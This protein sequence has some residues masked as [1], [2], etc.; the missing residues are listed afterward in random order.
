MSG[1]PGE[2]TGGMDARPIAEVPIH[3]TAPTRPTQPTQLP[4]ANTANPQSRTADSSYSPPILSSPART[5]PTT[6]TEPATQ[7][8][9]PTEPAAQEYRQPAAA[10]PDGLIVRRPAPTERV[11]VDPRDL[12]DI[13]IPVNHNVVI[14]GRRPEEPEEAPVPETRTAKEVIESIKDKFKV[15]DV[16]YQRAIEIQSGARRKVLEDIKRLGKNTIKILGPLALVYFGGSVLAGTNPKEAFETL[17]TFGGPILEKGKNALLNIGQRIVGWGKGIETGFFDYH[18]TNFKEGGLFQKTMWYTG[19]LMEMAGLGVNPD[20]LAIGATKVVGAPFA[21]IF[22]EGSVFYKG[23]FPTPILNENENNTNSQYIGRP[24]FGTFPSPGKLDKTVIP[25]VGI[26][27]ALYGM[28]KITRRIQDLMHK[29]GLLAV[30]DTKEQEKFLISNQAKAARLENK[31][32]EAQ[33]YEKALGYVDDRV[34]GIRNK[35]KAER[36]KKQKPTSYY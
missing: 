2:T 17:K 9:R 11:Q 4:T 24:D 20:K 33:Q 23:Q 8:T 35:M 28:H 34:K 12:A 6:P 10:E 19:R 5:A 22:G 27:G 29:K 7:V 3:I 21:G 25:G 1:N 26:L 30:Y 32:K 31:T 15:S 13:D 14:R 36:I 18:T 16:Q